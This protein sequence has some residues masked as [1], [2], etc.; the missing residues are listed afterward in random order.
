MQLSPRKNGLTSL[1]KE[2]RV[3]KEQGTEKHKNFFNLNFLPPIPTLPSW[4]PEEK[5]DLPH[6]LGKKAK[7]GPL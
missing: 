3:F 2:V 5:V 1:F 6:F 4:P 7:K